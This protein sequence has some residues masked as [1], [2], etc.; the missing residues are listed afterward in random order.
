MSVTKVVTPARLLRLPDPIVQQHVLNG[1]H[2][3][4]HASNLIHHGLPAARGDDRQCRGE[5]DRPP[6]FDGL[7]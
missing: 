3:G 7:V 4:E 2:G 1:V 6:H 5:A